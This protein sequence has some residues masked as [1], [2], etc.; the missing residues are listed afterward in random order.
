MQHGIRHFPT[1][2]TE[3]EQLGEIVICVDMIPV[4]YDV[5]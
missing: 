2:L 1:L 4:A 5:R 3:V